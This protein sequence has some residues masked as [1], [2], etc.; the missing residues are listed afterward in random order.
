MKYKIWFWAVC[1]VSTAVLA[2]FLF[3]HFSGGFSVYWQTLRQIPWL[4]WAGVGLSTVFFYLLDYVRLVALLSILNF[5]ISIPL[6]FKLTCI[7]YFVSSLT[8]SAELN[9]PAMTYMLT[10]QGLDVASAMAVSIVKSMYITLWICVIALVSLK[11]TP[12][13]HLPDHLANHLAL[14]LAPLCCLVL[15]LAVICS[16]PVRIHQWSEVGLSSTRIP[17]WLKYVIRG[18]DH[19]AHALSQITTS[20]HHMHLVSHLSSI[21]FVFVYVWIGYLLC[22]GLGIPLSF[23]RAITVFTNGLMVAYLAPIPG[24]V[25][26]TEIMTNYLLD[27]Q[28]TRVGMAAVLTQRILCWYVVLVPGVFFLFSSLNRA[29]LV[30]IF[31]KQS[32]EG[33]S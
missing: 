23:G 4:V 6:A 8:P 16:F 7:S 32:P 18:V 24:S 21:A 14:Y 26:I 1:L 27:P 5:N 13:V 10:K 12:S 2:P 25:G 20:T 19:G 33:E 15:A 31:A 9:I 29:S 17:R 30:Q 11:M 28:L 3:S 22:Y